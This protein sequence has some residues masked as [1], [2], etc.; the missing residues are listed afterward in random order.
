MKFPDMCILVDYE[1]LVYLRH[2]DFTKK[3]ISHCLN[4]LDF[5]LLIHT[6]FY[7]RSLYSSVLSI[8]DAEKNFFSV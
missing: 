7:A 1:C 5:T 4:V 8:R 6:I 2:S 3:R